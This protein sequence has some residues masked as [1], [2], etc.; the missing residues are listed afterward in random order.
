MQTVLPFKNSAISPFLTLVT[1]E[2]NS[3]NHR[4]FSTCVEFISNVGYIDKIKI[5]L[6]YLK[7][8]SVESDKSGLSTT[9]FNYMV[10]VYF[11]KTIDEQI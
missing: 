4:R 5:H 2:L 7:Q 11:L 10:G 6:I 8:K 1:Q 9:Y 3:T